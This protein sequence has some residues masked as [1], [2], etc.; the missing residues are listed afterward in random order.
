MMLMDTG[1]SFPGRP[2]DRPGQGAAPILPDQ[3]DDNE[4]VLQGTTRAQM[5]DIELLSACAAC[6]STTG[7]TLSTTA[8]AASRQ[9][10]RQRHAGRLHL[11]MT[12]TLRLNGQPPEQFTRRADLISDAHLP[13]LRRQRIAT[14]AIGRTHDEGVPAAQERIRA[15]WN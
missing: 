13:T 14:P 3:S 12:T 11:A 10:S 7:V 9:A 2:A 6:H 5:M 4:R 1:F 8:I 15:G